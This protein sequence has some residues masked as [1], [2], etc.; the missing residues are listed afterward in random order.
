MATTSIAME[1]AIDNTTHQ[2]HVDAAMDNENAS[3][4]TGS[5]GSPSSGPLS[6]TASSPAMS[7]SASGLAPRA[8]RTRTR[9]SSSVSMKS[10]GDDDHE[11]GELSDEPS[12]P[13]A[14]P[15]ATSIP[16]PPK[17]KKPHAMGTAESN[18]LRRAVKVVIQRTTDV[19]QRL[20]QMVLKIGVIV[21]TPRHPNT[22]FRVRFHNGK[23]LTFRASGLKLL[24]DAM[25]D[26]DDLNLDEMPNDDDLGP[27]S[28]DE[29]DVPVAASQDADAPLLKD[30]R[31]KIRFVDATKREVQDLKAYE[32][33]L[34]VVV[35]TLSSGIKV[36]FGSSGDPVVVKR[37]HLWA[38]PDDEWATEDDEEDDDD[39]DAA[40]VKS[41]KADDKS[42]TTTHDEGSDGDNEEEE[43]EPADTTRRKAKKKEQGTFLSDLDTDMW[44]GR[45]V[46]INV[47]K[48]AGQA[49][50]VLRSGNGWVQL[51]VEDG[52][53]NTA[54]RAYELTLLESLAE[55]ERLAPTKPEGSAPSTA[56]VAT[57][58]PS[59]DE[60]D[61]EGGDSGSQEERGSAVSGAR[62]R[63]HYA[64]SWIERKVYLPGNQ[65]TGIVKKADRDVCTVELENAN[66][67]IKV[68]KK[69]ELVLMED[70]FSIQQR[71][72]ANKA[73]SKLNIP[74]GVVLMG[75]TPQRYAAF[76][77]SVKKHVMRRRE[78]IKYRPNLM[79]WA[80]MLNTQYRNGA[81]DYDAPDV[82]DL[83]LLPSCSLCGVEK[84]D[85]MQE[86]NGACWNTQC[87]RCPVFEAPQE[88]I[89]ETLVCRYP[90]A[91]LTDALLSLKVQ[92]PDVA[93]STEAVQGPTP[94]E[95]SRKRKRRDNTS[96]QTAAVEE[97]GEEK[98]AAMDVSVPPPPLPPST[99]T[100]ET[101]KKP[102]E[103]NPNSTAPVMSYPLP[104]ADKFNEEVAVPSPPR[105]PPPPPPTAAPLPPVVLP[106]PAPVVVAS[107]PA[108]PAFRPQYESVF[109]KK[110]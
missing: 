96:P 69:Q 65:G 100:R 74:D 46:R 15:A 101:T 110:M 78:K 60:D 66:K 17:E 7:A 34:G 45:R 4:V 19:E 64:Q 24:K 41:T 103:A 91:P 54:K 82:M 44:I 5:S 67:T 25:A 90:Q 8:L 55:I 98:E 28:E 86:P 56:G 71:R 73:N 102:R 76:Q 48:F 26:G 40:S 29:M 72:R 12:A 3:D 53:E 42:Q 27:P 30:D 14:P 89:A 93:P 39:D 16:A 47:G 37:K 59:K 109:A 87:P 6:P 49:A 38:L 2:D 84:E 104:Q 13:P 18:G 92:V 62:R 106:P 97:K 36:Q 35:E 51:K 9:S 79:E 10:G 33:K 20:P 58:A 63:G 52:H 77:D 94:T 21:E 75:T 1:D 85:G 105:Q 81:C 43:D 108:A 11:D 68:F 23:I 88:A 22:W 80:S 70:E 83:F 61:K 107:A 32:G 50:I 99:S 95:A 31:V 57:A